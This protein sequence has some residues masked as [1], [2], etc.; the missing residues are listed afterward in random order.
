[1]MNTNVNA[2][3]N[4]LE[5]LLCNEVLVCSVLAYFLA[6]FIKIFTTL[7]REKTF[8]FK[9]LLGAGGM[10]SSHSSSVCALAF[11]VA[12]VMGVGSPVFALCVV[13]AGV[14]MYDATGV[15]REAG[16]HAKMLNQIIKDIFSGD[17]VYAQTA[18]KELIGHTP[19]QV[20]MGALLGTV[21]GLFF[22]SLAPLF[23]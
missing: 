4:I 15:R 13:L 1:M 18:L 17:P 21:I 10:P 19:M 2:G 22:P 23:A 9:R 7:Y 11:S 5:S 14:V 3:V 20:V 6:Q 12:R 16:T 8:D